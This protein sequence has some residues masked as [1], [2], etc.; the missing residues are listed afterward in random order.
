MP[1]PNQILLRTKLHRP[2]LPHDLLVRSRLVELLERDLNHQLFL[3]CAP[4]GY[5]KTTLIGTWLE[6]M[7]AGRGEM[8]T[9]LP[10]AWLSLDE[11]DSDLNLF[12]RYFIA[13]LRTNFA[14]ACEQTLAL[15]QAQQLLPQ[16]ILSATFS[17]DLEDLPGESILV[18]DDYHTI[19]GVEVHNL[20]SELARHWPKSLHL[21]LISRISPPIPLDRLRANGM[22]SEIRTR[23]LRFTPEETAAYLS[24]SQYA[25]LSQDTLHLLEDRFEGWPAGLHLAALSLRSVSSQESVKMAL[26]SENTNVTGYLLDEVLTH[27]FPAIHSFLLKTS[28]LDQFCASLC[29]AVMGEVDTAW[30]VRACLD[31]IE[32]SEL[33]IIP[34]DNHREWYRYHH[35]FQELLQQRLSIEMMPDQVNNLHRWASV[36]FEEHGLVDEALHHALAAGDLGLAARQMSTGLCEVLNHE[37]RL[38]LERWLRLLPEEMIQQQPE[39]LML[40]AWE[41]Q[42][43]WRLDLQAKVIQQVEELLDSGVGASLPVDVLQILRGQ[44]LLIRAQLAYFSNQTARAIDLCQQVLS[45]FPPSWTFVRGGAMFYQGMSMQASGQAQE[46]ERLLLAE[47]ESYGNKTDA[48]ALLVLESLGHTYLNTGHLD[49]SMRIA[50]VLHQGATHSR[51]A[52]MEN[53]GDWF[54]GMVCYQ[55]NEL[56][57]AS[58]HFS[59]IVKN[60][61]IAQITTY[62]DAVAGL[63]MIHQNKGESNE[64]LQ[65]VESISQFDLE[66]RGTEDERTRS[67]RA[68]LMLWQGNL[69]GAGHWADSYTDPPPDIPLF[70]IAE[71]Q[72]TRVSVLV[73]RGTDVDLQS[74]LQILDILDEIVERTNNTRYKIEILTL[75][76]LTLNAQGRIGE[77]NTVLKQ[78]VKLSRPGGFIRVFVD[79]GKPMQDMLRPLAE[80]GYLEEKIHLILAGFPPDDRTP[81]SSESRVQLS[82]TRLH[83]N[84]SLVEPL[85]PRELEVLNLLREPISIKEIAQKLHISYA[86]T[87]RHTINLYGKLSVHQRKEAV[88]RAI[89]L[90]ILPA[91]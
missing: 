29:E 6:R 77:A 17:N 11:N 31:W 54:L 39:L 73:A 65:L 1:D 2:S 56:E 20:L 81:V 8:T 33:F 48:Y 58:Q 74:A 88:A 91:D 44:I 69:E 14:E 16:E 53:W 24:R 61:Y 62:R 78:A 87:K 47:Y 89:E 46:A 85:T 3:V 63:A 64:A 12:L 25:F 60:Q 80:Q 5:G 67:L 26:S 90:D 55:R 32:R 70:W 79:L 45:I 49:Q 52:I 19:R 40:R 50:Q 75:R 34:L 42:F 23:D 36:W 68:R 4:A 41:M 51:Q 28:I 35:L 15:L 30:N 38:T 72:V 59:Q 9:S 83:G 43:T 7:T 22:V 84:S 57:A 86:T 27:Q 13:A 10:S 76:A 18:L 66:Q 37:D 82:H 21:V 71:P